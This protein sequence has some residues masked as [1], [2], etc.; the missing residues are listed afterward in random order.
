MKEKLIKTLQ[1][2]Y[3]EFGKSPRNADCSKIEYLKGKGTY[4][5]YFGTFGDALEAAGLPRNRKKTKILDDEGLL[6]TI[7]DYYNKYKEVPSQSSCRKDDLLASHST[8]CKH[9]GSFVKALKLAGFEDKL[10]HCHSIS[11][12]KELLDSL[13]KFFKEYNRTP[14]PEDYINI[15]YLFSSTTYLNKFG[16]IKKAREL[17][18]I[19]KLTNTIINEPIN[20][21]KILLNN[22]ERFYKEYNRAPSQ[23]ECATV[24]YLNSWGTYYYK[25]G[26]LAAA[27]K[28]LGIEKVCGVS[29]GELDLAA[30]ISEIYEGEIL[31]SDRKILKGKELDIVIPELKLAFEYNGLY[32]HSDSIKKDKNYHINKTTQCFREGYRL[33]HI[34]ESEWV[35]KQELVKSRI[36]NMFK[37]SKRIHARKCIIKEVSSAD[38]RVFLNENHIQGAVNGS[39]KLGLYFEESLVALMTFCKSR[40]SN[41]TEY[42]LLRYCNKINTAVVGGASKLFKHFIKSHNPK[43]IVSYSDL[44][45][46]TGD[47]YLK[48]GFEYS[49]SSKPNYWYFK[50][51]KLESR[52][53]YQKHKL[54]NILEEFDPNLTEYQNM[55]NNGYKRIYDCGNEVFEYR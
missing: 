25:F 35:N 43:S 45:W 27:L 26:S 48:L 44:R 54:V 6:K 13:I 50:G 23:A 36:R 40:Y 24:D 41:N 8:Y 38:S 46:N 53:K 17:A 16:S 21:N 19:S 42:E 2:F 31:T 37:L 1:K 11:T 39:V 20:E 49:H 34:F 51:L 5:R 32:W 30:F 55:L 7:K 52:V 9:F 4:A 10:N 33:V 14:L 28:S 3:E 18:G 15:P 12:D 47:L 22:L 29:L